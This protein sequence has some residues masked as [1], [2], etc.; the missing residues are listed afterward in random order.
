MF[1]Q[2]SEFQNDC[3]RP[4]QLTQ[5]LF[6]WKNRFLKNRYPTIFNDTTHPFLFLTTLISQPQLLELLLLPLTIMPGQ[7]VANGLMLTSAPLQST[8]SDITCSA[9]SECPPP[10][11]FCPPKFIETPHCYSSLVCLCPYWFISLKLALLSWWQ[12]W[13]WGREECLTGS[14]HCFMF[15]FF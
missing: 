11:I 8:S 13:E 1:N 15:F 4:L 9:Q 2:I 6:G 10:S 12:S 5:Q 7:S 3:L 14:S